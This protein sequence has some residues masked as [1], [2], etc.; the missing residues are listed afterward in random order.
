MELQEFIDE[1][2]RQIIAGVK[3]A[4]EAE[5]GSYINADMAGASFSGNL[6]NGGPYGVATRVDFDVSVSAETSGGGG[7]K[8]VVFGVGAEGGTHHS[9]TSANRISFSIPIRLPLGD[10]TLAEEVRKNRMLE[11]ERSLETI[12]EAGRR[13]NNQ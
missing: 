4:Q 3:K 5:D 6:T 9:A 10:T 8:L 11:N 1:T 13:L 2:L 12:A 7:A